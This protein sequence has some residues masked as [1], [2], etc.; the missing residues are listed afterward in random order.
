MPKHEAEK[1]VKNIPDE[2]AALAMTESALIQEMQLIFALGEYVRLTCFMI[3]GMAEKSVNDG[4]PE[5]LKG[6]P[7]TNKGRRIDLTFGI[8]EHVLA[9][10]AEPDLKVKGVV[11]IWTYTGF[12]HYCVGYGGRSVDRPLTYLEQEKLLEGLGPLI[13]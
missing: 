4:E 9:M 2:V 5:M 1:L 3:L 7:W 8:P 10:V 12:A 13:S 6:P 11:F